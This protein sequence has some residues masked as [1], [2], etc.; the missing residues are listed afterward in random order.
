VNIYIFFMPNARRAVK[1]VEESR[2][3]KVHIFC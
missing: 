3:L 2:F 1:I